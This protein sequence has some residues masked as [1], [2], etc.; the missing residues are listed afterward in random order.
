LWAKNTRRFDDLTDNATLLTTEQAEAFAIFSSTREKF[1][2]LPAKMFEI[3][4]GKEWNL[5]N[6]WLGTKAAPTASAIMEQLNSMVVNQKY[7]MENDA[8]TV[9]DYSTFLVTLEWILLAIG[10]VI[11]V[12]VALF[13]TRLVLKQ[14]GDEPK[15]LQTAAEQIADG[16][17][18]VTING[19]TGIAASINRM[20]SQLKTSTEQTAKQLWLS[21]GLSGTSDVIRGETDIGKMASRICEF[22]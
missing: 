16:N 6:L 22:L 19:N 17:L 5:A 21:E 13:I 14:V 1:N 20:V 3:R 2:P 11:S 9:I 8:A 18:D 12:I 7:L 4:G 10:I 15:R